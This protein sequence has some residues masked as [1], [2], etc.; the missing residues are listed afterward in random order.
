MEFVV[1]DFNSQAALLEGETGVCMHG[2]LVRLGVCIAI[3][4]IY[5]QSIIKQTQETLRVDHSFL[6]DV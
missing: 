4:Y 1:V 5:R 3:V 6:Y 2:M